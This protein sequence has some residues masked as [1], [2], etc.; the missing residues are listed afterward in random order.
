MSYVSIRG[1]GVV[2]GLYGNSELCSLQVQS[3]DEDV[4]KKIALPS[5]D[6]SEYHT[7]YDSIAPIVLIPNNSHYRGSYVPDTNLSKTRIQ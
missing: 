1:V 3:S 4:P 2:G 7:E 6:V 5:S